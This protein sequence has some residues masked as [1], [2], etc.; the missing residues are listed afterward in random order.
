MPSSRNIVTADAS[1]ITVVGVASIRDVKVS[2]SINLRNVHISNLP[3]NL[4][5]VQN[6]VRD[7]RCNMFHHN[8]CIF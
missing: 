2:S 1:L 6:F 4:V 5:F 3:T 8:R 7:L